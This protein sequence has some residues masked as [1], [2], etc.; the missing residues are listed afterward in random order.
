MSSTR[1]CTSSGGGGV[2]AATA[3]ETMKFSAMP[4]VP[5]PSGEIPHNQCS[6]VLRSGLTNLKKMIYAAVKVIPTIMPLTAPA[7][8][9]RFEKMPITMAGKNE[10]AARPKANATT[11]ATNPGGL[12]RSTQRYRL[13]HPPQ[14]VRQS[15]PVSPVASV[16]SSL[17]KDHA[18]Q[19][20]R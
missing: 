10:L 4:R 6:D 17:S 19:Q 20:W 18:Q 15:I 3:M 9:M 5:I 16:S 13:L 12:C 11:C 14:C 1:A 8:F 7:L 2:T